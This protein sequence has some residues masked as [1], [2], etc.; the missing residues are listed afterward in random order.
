[1][2]E[3]VKVWDKIINTETGKEFAEWL[4]KEY[5]IRYFS[6]DKFRKTACFAYCDRDQDRINGE[7]N[8]INNL[9]I[10]WL[11]SKGY[12]IYTP[13][14]SKPEL[15][16]RIAI[17]NTHERSIH[18]PENYKKIIDLRK[19]YDTRQEAIQAGVRKAFELLEGDDS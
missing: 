17:I 5:Q 7:K 12:I 2:R 9:A 15:N 8:I 1:M 11:D 19:Y 13:H 16:F 10:E 3:L 4:K 6:V 18:N 14:R